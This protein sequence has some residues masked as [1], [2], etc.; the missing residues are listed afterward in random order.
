VSNQPAANF[1]SAPNLDFGKV[2]ASPSYFTRGHVSF[3]VSPFVNAGLQPTRATF[4]WYQASAQGAGCLDVALHRLVAPWS[5]GAVTWQTQPAH[6]PVET[7]RLCVGNSFALGWKE[8]DVTPLVRAWLDGSA[9]NHGFVIRDPMEITAGASR[10]GLGHSREFGNP[11]LR[12]YLE[13]DFAQPFGA[14]CTTH[15]T[16]PVLGVAG[17]SALMGQTLQLRLGELLPGSLGLVFF[18]LDNTSWSG[19]PLPFS[20]AVLGY[21]A[22]DLLVEPATSVVIGIASGTA[23]TLPITVPSAPAFDG[24]PLYMQG[25]A[26]TPATLLEATNGL[27]VRLWL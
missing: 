14:G 3:D 13:I 22:C 2:F 6:D 25:F 12:P 27:G 23:Q 11:A 5:E 10:P 9:P 19:T 1:G 16:V 7:T 20:L 24:L 21:P 17:G 4:Y 26:L 8:F 18:G 15:A